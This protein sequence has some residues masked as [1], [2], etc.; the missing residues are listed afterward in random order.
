M[1]LQIETEFGV[2]T[3]SLHFVAC[4]QVYK[5]GYREVDTNQCFGLTQV[6][7][8]VLLCMRSL[9]KLHGAF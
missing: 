3:G 4:N 2:L 7:W 5:I 9:V 6:D 1:L 8:S